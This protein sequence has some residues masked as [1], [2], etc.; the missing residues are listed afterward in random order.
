MDGARRLWSAEAHPVP[1]L[2]AAL[3]ASVA[4]HLGVMPGVIAPGPGGP[5]PRTATAE[6]LRAWIVQRSERRPSGERADSQAYPRGRRRV[7]RARHTGPWGGAIFPCV[8]AGPP[9]DPSPAHRTA[10]SRGCSRANGPRRDESIHRPGRPRR[11]DRAGLERSSV[12]R[13]GPRGVSEC[14]LL[15]GRPERRGGQ[16]P[17]ADRGD[18][19][20]GRN[21]GKR[22]AVPAP[23]G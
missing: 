8:R 12:R 9:A 14:A 10:L 4:L 13:V 1:R 2:G 21:P 23:S 20:A 11:Q 22:A 17:D 7:R 19:Q 16:E 3:A 15:S 18:L 5:G 6:P